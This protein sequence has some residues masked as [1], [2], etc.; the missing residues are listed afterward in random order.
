LGGRWISKFEAGLVYRVSSRTARATQ[1]NPVSKK[2]KTKNQKT[3]TKQQ[4][5]KKKR[6]KRKRGSVWDI[7]TGYV[8]GSVTCPGYMTSK[9]ESGL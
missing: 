2:T 5:Q 6:K 9:R 7:T 8:R 1:R 3:T 4:Q